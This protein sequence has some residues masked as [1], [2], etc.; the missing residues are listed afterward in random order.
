MSKWNTS[1]GLPD[2]PPTDH[3]QLAGVYLLAIGATTETLARAQ[4]HGLLAVAQAV[5]R[6]AGAVLVAGSDGADRDDPAVT[7]V[8][9]EIMTRWHGSCRPSPLPL[10]PQP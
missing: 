1:D 4:A 5:D 10:P 6:L 9:D 2:L 3:A 7:H 8:V